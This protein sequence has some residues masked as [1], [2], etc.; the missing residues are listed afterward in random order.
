MD[1]NAD[2][3]APG[4][5][6][7]VLLCGHWEH[8]PPCPIAAHHTSAERDGAIVRLRILFATEPGTQGMVRDRIH[9]ALAGGHL[10]GA[11]DLAAARWR[12]LKGYG[13]AVR[14][15]EVAHAARLS[16]G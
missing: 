13:S 6:I 5:A 14:D 7:T 1:P 3:A 10:A 11:P 12:L 16:H 15:D 4:A 8:K 9:E 2:L